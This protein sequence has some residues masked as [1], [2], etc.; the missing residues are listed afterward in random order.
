MYSFSYCF[1]LVGGNDNQTRT[2]E[3][4]CEPGFY[5]RDGVKELCQGGYY[6]STFGLIHANCTGPCEP[7]YYCPTGSISATEIMCGDPSRFC[8]E[9]STIPSFVA[10]GYYSIGR[11]FF[12]FIGSVLCLLF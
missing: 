4:L 12:L 10:L 6:G 9:N 11:L 3:R 7:G 8:P 2:S 1:C 5:C